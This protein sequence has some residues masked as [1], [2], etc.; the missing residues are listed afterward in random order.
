[1]FRSTRI[2]LF[3]SG[4]ADWIFVGGAMTQV[5]RITAMLVSKP[6]FARRGQREPI[7]ASIPARTNCGETANTD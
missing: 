2:K 3:L 4:N 6:E 1:M 7:M 5:E